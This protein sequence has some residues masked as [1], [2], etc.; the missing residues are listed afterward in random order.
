MEKFWKPSNRNETRKEG[1]DNDK[2]YPVKVKKKS[3]KHEN[4]TKQKIYSTREQK[5]CGGKQDERRPYILGFFF[6]FFLELYREITR[7]FLQQ[8]TFSIVWFRRRRHL[9]T[10]T[11]DRLQS[12]APIG[13]H[14]HLNR[15]RLRMLKDG[16]EPIG[17]KTELTDEE[18][19]VLRR[20]QL[21]VAYGRELGHARR[22]LHRHSKVLVLV[23]AVG[24]CGY[25][26]YRVRPDDDV[27]E[28]ELGQERV[29]AVGHARVVPDDAHEVVPDVSLFVVELRVVFVVRH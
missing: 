17:Q 26:A 28:L 20:D 19:Q 1:R 14:L 13:H 29:E 25:G 5:F 6:S 22:A 23:Q 10:K 18:R 4:K 12:S 8:K 24:E 3:K 15:I 9:T 11:L 16:R 2:T 27:D 7:R 21:E